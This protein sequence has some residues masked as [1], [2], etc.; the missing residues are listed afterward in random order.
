MP[1]P[2]KQIQVVQKLVFSTFPYNPFP[3]INK[4][5]RAEIVQGPLEGLE[6]I[7]VE[8][9]MDLKIHPVG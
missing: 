5:D 1:I 8:K 2:D 9:E 7:L 3:Y 4:S 6:V